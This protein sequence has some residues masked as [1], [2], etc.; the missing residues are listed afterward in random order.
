MLD[1]L[2]LRYKETSLLKRLLLCAIVALIPAGLLYLDESSVIEEEYAAAETAEKAAASKLLE[3]DN[4]L[5]NLAKVEGELAFTR[6]QL[7]KA[8][9]R[10]PET[11]AM[12]E[13]LRT[14][15]KTAKDS[16]VTVRLFE[17]MQD[18]MRGDTYK[19][20]EVPIKISVEAHDYSQLCEWVDSL[21]GIK[22]KIYLK[23][24]K[25]GRRAASHKD[26]KLGVLAAPAPAVDLDPSIAAE[27]QG[28][29]ARENFLVVMD[30]NFS[31]YKMPSAAQVEFPD[32]AA[33]DPKNPP[34]N[35]KETAPKAK[36]APTEARE[37]GDKYHIEGK[38]GAST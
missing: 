8:E 13:I 18:I 16:K 30:A 19:Y 31:L 22:S 27:Q 35:K 33:L 32:P 20:S 15:G 9:S 28:R 38:K 26:E 23:A 24:W 29:K 3:A 6:E 14:V 17:P 37:K 11:I 21:A 2:K 10:L 25:L 4:T 12:D 36:E 5:K 34:E 1:E 7:K